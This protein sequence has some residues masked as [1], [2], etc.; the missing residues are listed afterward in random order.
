MSTNREKCLLTEEKSEP[1]HRGEW[2]ASPS[3][4]LSFIYS[5]NRYFLVGNEVQSPFI[6]PQVEP[7]P[8]DPLYLSHL[9]REPWGLTPLGSRAQARAPSLSLAAGVTSQLQTRLPDT[10]CP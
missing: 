2:I 8:G 7:A 9:L 5:F 3:F 10:C 1:K 4:I 6:L